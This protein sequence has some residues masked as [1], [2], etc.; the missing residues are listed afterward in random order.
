MKY[1]IKRDNYK[2]FNVF[3]DNKLNPRAY[4][5]PFG[6][7]EMLD[8]CS[9]LDERTKSDKILMLSG[10]W[11][12]FYNSKCKTLPDVLNTNEV[13]WDKI[14][15]PST[16]QRTGYEKPFYLNRRYQFPKKPPHIPHD[17][18]VGVYR[19]QFEYN[20][21]EKTIITFLGVCSCL[22]LYV[23]GEY[24]G[25]SEGSHNKAEFD[26]TEFLIKGENELVALVYKFC[27]GSY[28]E[29][30][31]MYRENGIFRDVYLTAEGESY[32]EDIRVKTAKNTDG[33]YSLKISIDC[34]GNGELQADL[35]GF[36]T[37]KTAALATTNLSYDA[38][39][40]E[41]WSAEKPKLYQLKLQLNH[42][43]KSEYIRLYVG[44]KDIK[45]ESNV[46]YYNGKKI[47]MKGVNHHD[48]DPIKGYAVNIDDYERDVKLMKA[49][50]V[51][52]VRC[53]HYPKDP[54]FLAL[55]DHYGLYV[56]DEADIETH[57]FYNIPS[58]PAANRL[59]NDAKWLPQ[60][61]DRV[62][63]M[64]K[65]D[66]NYCSVAMWSL[67]N[68]AGGYK[69]Q[70][71]CYELVKS[72]SDVP[73]HYEGVSHN[74]ERIHYD[75]VS[76]MYP[77]HARVASVAEGKAPEGFLRVPYFMCEYAHAMGV[78]PGSLEEYWDLIYSADN[79]MGG[80]IWEFVDHSHFD[81][82]GKYRWTYGG[83]YGEFIHDKNFCVDGL[84]YPDRRPHT[85]A[86]QMK[87]VYRPIKARLDGDKV[88]FTN[89]MA[90]SDTSNITINYK[91]TTLG[92]V[93]D[94]GSFEL[95]IAPLSEGFK[96]IK[97]A[98]KPDTIIAF[99]YVD[100]NDG[101]I[102][103]KEEVQVVAAQPVK[104]YEGEAAKFSQDKKEV[105]VEFEGGSLSFSKAKGALTSYKLG[106][107][108]L[109]EDAVRVN[110]TRAPIDNEMFINIL[111]KIIGF[112]RN[113]YS[114]KFRSVKTQDGATV[115]RCVNK[116]KLNLGSLK[117]V[118]DYKVFK[119]GS[120]LIEY[121]RKNSCAALTQ[122]P[123]IGL[124]LP[125]DDDFDNVVYFGKSGESYPDMVNYATTEINSVKVAELHEPYIMPQENGNRMFTRWAQLT[126][127][128]GEGIKISAV[129]KLFA[130][131]AN[132]YST[133]NLLEAKHIEDLKR[134][135]DIEV[136][137]DGYTRPVGSDS[138]G[139]L[140][141]KEYLY[142]KTKKYAV[143]IQPLKGK[144]LNRE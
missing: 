109:L 92:L 57:G 117:F 35:E 46:F 15:V 59:S 77:F 143:L 3:K 82:D 105:K 1:Q 51:N 133:Q 12:F 96:D 139:P 13:N 124:L 73:V 67:G 84:F 27:N 75:V 50:N 110:I 127:D 138:C 54:I 131:G 45:I 22:E 66:G 88:I 56:V 107:E 26:L 33:T 6:N 102:I 37:I 111:F 8:A 61:L 130:F 53:S 122:I 25:Y 65:N 72:L 74:K 55:C 140:P 121:T 48:S 137:V 24:V 76:E 106:D 97:I 108:E 101:S 60:Y 136:F 70:D 47:K 112:N 14:V 126:N 30:Q 11:E 141:L 23:N 69:N 113:K 16:W 63:S 43:K 142:D 116:A 81:E 87:Y 7:L 85:G 93:C 5:I 98:N 58:S 64:V 36:D 9:Y 79:L 89:T 42:N 120:L 71:A 129:E 28:L 91:V 83:D 44:F 132:D 19:K 118:V 39:S 134:D 31:D 125:I 86:K 34:V 21:S 78:G 80:C 52:T 10:E 29:C 104:G 4:F 94:G 32:I 20:P 144:K 95:S 135:E 40:V 128:K 115:I 38:L 62:E 90:F 41:E 100:K 68:E 99:E 49:Y 103:A 119:D 17:I 114:C 18:P 2:N 123:R